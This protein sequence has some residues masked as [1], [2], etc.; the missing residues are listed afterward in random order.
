MTIKKLTERLTRDQ[1]PTFL[2][3]KRPFSNFQTARIESLV[4]R[5]RDKQLLVLLVHF[6]LSFTMKIALILS[7]LLAFVGGAANAQPVLDERVLTLALESAKLSALAYNDA[8]EYQVVDA[9]GTVTGY[10]HPDYEEINFFTQEPDQAI[11]AKKDGRCFIAFRGTSAT[12]S[13]WEQNLDLRE[14][15]LY[16]NNDNTTGEFCEVRRGYSDFLR[17]DEFGLAAKDLQSCIPSC[18]DPN[19]CVVITGHSQGGA[20]AAVASILAYDLMPTIFTFGMPPAAKEA[21]T[22]IPGERL[23][24]FVNH[25]KETDEDDDLGFDPVPFSPTLF[26]HSKHYG[27]YLLVGPDKTA[28][29]YLGLDQNYTFEPSINDRVNEIAAHNMNGTN[30]SYLSRIEGLLE[31]GQTTGFPVTTDGFA[32][33]VPCEPNYSELVRS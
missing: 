14:D 9:N 20:S 7:A 1:V 17:S 8:T 3:G 32:E 10:Q 30:H 2:S 22:L 26:S 21:C 27:Y 5:E 24:R 6:W 28:A 16:K 13:D 19:D 23:Y 11:V 12:A 33:G 18:S 29:K 4:T 25:R 31:T 15:R